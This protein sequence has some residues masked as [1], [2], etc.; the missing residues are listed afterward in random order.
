MLEVLL[1]TLVLLLGEMLP[2]KWE[3]PHAAPAVCTWPQ[4]ANQGSP[5]SLSSPP[6]LHVILPAYP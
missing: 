5:D 1:R 2:G 3:V 4:N 6:S